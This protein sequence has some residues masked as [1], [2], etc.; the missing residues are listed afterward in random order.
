VKYDREDAIAALEPHWPLTDDGEIDMKACWPSLDV[1]DGWSD[2]IVFAVMIGE[3]VNP[4]FAVNQV[5]E[6]L[7]GLRFYCTLPL[8][9]EL[10]IEGLALNVCETCGEFGSLSYSDGPGPWLKTLCKD[11][12][13]TNY[14]QYLSRSDWVAKYEPDDDC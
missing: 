12:L 3:A 5:K 7:G 1:G 4:N 8:V 10:M 14:G 11:H 6:K 2:V 13:E 9:T